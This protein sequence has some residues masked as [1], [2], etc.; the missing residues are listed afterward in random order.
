MKILIFVDKLS[1]NPTKDERDTLEEAENVKI[2]LIKL[3]HNVLTKTFSLNLEENLNII[4][5]INPDLIFNLV[6]TL[7]GS[8][9]LHLAPLLFEKHKIKYTGGNSKALFLTGDKVYTKQLLK[10]IKIKT[11]KYYHTDMK[12]I[13]LSLINKTVIVKSRSEEASCGIDDNSV[14]TFKCKKDISTFI[15]ANKD[16]F[17]EEFIDGKEF[18]I[19]ILNINS[20][21]TVL[22]IARMDFINFSDNKPKILNYKS[23]WD[24]T[25]FE[26]LHTKRSFDLKDESSTLLKKMESISKKCFKELGSKGY[27]RVDFRV[28]QNEIPYVLEI[29]M[30]PCIN[31]DSGFVA[32]ANKRGINFNDLIN[33][34]IKE[35]INE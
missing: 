17:V 9:T 7:E 2:A 33:Y 31:I 3:G 23:K 10:Q 14:I 1:S 34:I 18:S 11:P 16:M 27:L 22:P 35:E 6:E 25:S 8:D 24:E 4:K 26:Y 30:N 21:P 12:S 20:K 32:A 5:K 13:N 15:D 28:D 19:S 29:N